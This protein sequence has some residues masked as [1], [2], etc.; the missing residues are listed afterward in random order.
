MSEHRLL[1][2]GGVHAS[3]TIKDRDHLIPVIR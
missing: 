1:R 3:E 2:F